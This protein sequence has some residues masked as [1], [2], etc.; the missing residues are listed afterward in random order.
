VA[1]H[2]GPCFDFDLGRRPVPARLSRR[3]LCAI[4][5]TMFE[6]RSAGVARADGVRI[7]YISP[8]KALAKDVEKNLQIPLDGIC[9]IAKERGDAF[10]RPPSRGPFGRHAPKPA[11]EDAPRSA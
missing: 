2:P 9:A 4:D 5:R 10:Y 3:F 6:K 11:P 1:P 7:L 8:V